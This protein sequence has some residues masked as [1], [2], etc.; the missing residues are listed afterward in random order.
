[1]LSKA[2]PASPAWSASLARLLFPPRDTRFHPRPET[3]P[4]RLGISLRWL[5]ISFRTAGGASR[6][7]DCRPPVTRGGWPRSLAVGPSQRPWAGPSAH[8][9]PQPT[10]TKGRRRLGTTSPSRPRGSPGQGPR[11]SQT[12]SP[13]LPSPS[14]R[15]RASPAP[16]EQPR[17]RPLRSRSG[18]RKAGA[19][20][21]RD[22]S[23]ARAALAGAANRT[24]AKAEPRAELREAGR[25]AG[26]AKPLGS[27]LRDLTPL[28]HPLNN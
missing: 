8:G 22:G 14:E 18:L 16:P 24:P 25:P 9:C 3:A 17:G 21:S 20:R 4:S 1:M 5:W 13:E 27:C 28:L 10:P 23:R 7:P 6:T 12:S 19:G 11:T 26:Q 15:L 2:L